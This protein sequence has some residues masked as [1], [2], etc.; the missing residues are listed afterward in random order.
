MCLGRGSLLASRP[1][2]VQSETSQIFHQHKLWQ[3]DP[4]CQK[5]RQNRHWWGCLPAEAAAA[6]A[7]VTFWNSQTVAENWPKKTQQSWSLSMFKDRL[8]TY[9][10]PTETRWREIKG[11]Q[12]MNICLLWK[13]ECN[14]N[15]LHS[16]ELPKGQN[17][18]QAPDFPCQPGQHLKT[19][20]TS[21]SLQPPA[22]A[23]MSW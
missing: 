15:F 9:H 8:E 6:H 20:S 3:G 21:F 13:S 2:H 11:K 5:N 16:K 7:C 23:T 14:T 10:T 1:G 17:V 18:F 22:T 19:F 12:T 4:L